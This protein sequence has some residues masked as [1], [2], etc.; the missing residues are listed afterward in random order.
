MTGCEA[1]RQELAKYGGW[2]VSVMFAVAQAENR[3]CDPAVHNLT[4]SEN[5]GVCVGS[6]GALQVGCV[7]Y[8][9]QDRDSL[10]I[11]VAIAHQVW[12]KQG[13]EA[14]TQYNNL[15]YRRFL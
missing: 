2:D 7:H 6:Y 10:A 1:V 12:Q 13:Y 11:N 4:L 8:A 3:T 15:E 9:G 14:W 5:H